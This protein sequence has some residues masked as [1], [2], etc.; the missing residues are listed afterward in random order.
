MLLC[1]YVNIL[2]SPQSFTNHVFKGASCL[3]R[4]KEVHTLTWNTSYQTGIHVLIC[5]NTAVPWH[6]KVWEPK[7]HKTSNLNLHFVTLLSGSITIFLQLFVWD[8]FWRMTAY[9]PGICKSSQVFQGFPISTSCDTNCSQP[10]MFFLVLVILLM[11]FWN[12]II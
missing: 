9:T 8:Y 1:N 10:L 6:E 4:K 3:T 12:W 5:V 2:E 11:H 7:K